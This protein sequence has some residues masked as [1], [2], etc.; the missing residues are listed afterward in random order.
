M[1][2]KHPPVAPLLPLRAENLLECHRQFPWRGLIR[3]TNPKQFLGG[4]ILELVPGLAGQCYRAGSFGRLEQH[5]RRGV[6]DSFHRQGVARSEQSFSTVRRAVGGSSG[7][8]FSCPPTHDPP[9]ARVAFWLD[10]GAGIHRPSSSDATTLLCIG[11][12]FP[13]RHTTARSSGA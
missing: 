2:A 11:W 13:G 5:H 8:T 12:R 4:R 10:G 3:K 9:H 6:A 1:V 7:K